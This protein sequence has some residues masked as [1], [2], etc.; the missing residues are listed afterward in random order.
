MAHPWRQARAGD[1]GTLSNYLGIVGGC[2][3]QPLCKGNGSCCQCHG[4]IQD[5]DFKPEELLC[6]MHRGLAC[7]PPQHNT[8]WRGTA[9]LPLLLR[10][11]VEGYRGLLKTA[12]AP[13]TRSMFATVPLGSSAL[14]SVTT[15]V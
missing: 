6:S 4:K 15:L 10:V 7:P 9:T 2:L 11:P 5:H 13:S 12:G 3:L 1:A 14:L 8:V